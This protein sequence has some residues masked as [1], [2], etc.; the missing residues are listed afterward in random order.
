MIYNWIT[1]P[2]AS[3]TKSLA[4]EN[5]NEIRDLAEENNEFGALARSLLKSFSQKEELKEE[6]SIRKKTE[7]AL[8]I[9]DQRF[10]DVTDAA[11]EFIWETNQNLEFTYLSERVFTTLR[12]MPGELYG[13]T[14]YDLLS[15]NRLQDQAQLKKIF[16]DAKPFKNAEVLV[17]TKRLEEIYLSISGTP[18]YDISG[19]II[20][21][22]GTA[23][24]I[25]SA[26][27]VEKE[28]LRAKESAESAN[29]AK[30]EFLANMSHEIRTPMNGILGMTDLALSTNLNEEQRSYI[31]LVKTSA[32]NLLVVM[33]F[34][35]LT[36][37]RY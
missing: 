17:Y 15:T 35:S 28:L 6:I 18:Y 27:N 11:G 24:D 25:T 9:S 7:I 34:L 33:N 8:S 14:F 23:S 3:I 36:L 31:E 26:K 2:L 37:V 10:R 13:K 32:E 4:T 1:S 19:N 5:P 30:S 16:S 12:Y 29:R 22:R 21:Y 20:G